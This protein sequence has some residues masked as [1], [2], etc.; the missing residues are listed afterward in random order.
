MFPGYPSPWFNSLLPKYAELI[1]GY[2][3]NLLKGDEVL[4]SGTVEALPLLRE[5]YRWALK[6]KSYPTIYV[7]DPITSEIFYL[8][9]S[10][11]QLEHITPVL[12]T[13]YEEYNVHITILGEVHTRILSGIPPEKIAL[14]RK[15][16]EPLVSRYLEEAA[17]GE[18]RWTIAPYPTLANAQEAGMRPLE[19]EMFVARATKITYEDPV[20]EWMRQSEKQDKLIRDIL[21]GSDEIRVVA[22]GTDLTVK[23]G[24]RTWISDDGHENM[25][26][27]EVFTGPVEDGVEGCVTFN[28]PQI[29]SGVEIDGV[30]LCFREG[31]I[32][33]HSAVKGGELL[34][35]L[36]SIDEGARRLGEFAFG[37]N[38]DIN[39][40]TKD[41]LF[42]EK[43]GGTIH[44]A[45]GNGYPETGSRNRSAIHWDLILDMRMPDAKVYVDGDLVYENGRFRGWDEF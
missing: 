9:A 32:V 20:S 33:E 41:I 2:S 43:I 28:M 39:R 26:G 45:L 16:I 24:G 4:I 42:D 34:S 23:V 36:I 13:M 38:Y 10:E 12:K 40:Q 7:R 14:A 27:G 1:T 44:M 17:R 15:A 25:P 18:K 21:S 37:L 3:V 19:Y 5:V 6:A 31:K 22:P 30:R 11:D 8:E 35:R 29:Y